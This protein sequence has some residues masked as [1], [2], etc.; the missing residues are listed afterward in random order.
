MSTPDDTT[1]D[2]TTTTDAVTT[3]DAESETDVDCAVQL[4]TQRWGQLSPSCIETCD[5]ETKQYRALSKGC[6]AHY[7]RWF[8]ETNQTYVLTGVVVAVFF[9]VAL[10]FGGSGTTIVA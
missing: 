10:Y 4:S 1:A 9:I 6:Q 2:E 8:Y 3:T 5:F 7:L